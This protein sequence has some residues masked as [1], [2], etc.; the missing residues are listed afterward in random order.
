MEIP[1]TKR[2]YILSEIGQF[3][4]IFGLLFGFTLGIISFIYQYWLIGTVF[5]LFAFLYSLFY[6]ICLSYW[7]IVRFIKDKKIPK[8][9]YK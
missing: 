6:D 7:S 4:G 9:L 1:L 2:N 5:I 3:V 8:E